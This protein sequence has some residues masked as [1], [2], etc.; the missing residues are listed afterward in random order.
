MVGET[1]CTSKIFLFE[2]TQFKLLSQLKVSDFIKTYAILFH[3][4]YTAVAGLETVLQYSINPIL[5]E[6]GITF[7]RCFSANL[8]KGH[9]NTN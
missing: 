3:K 4:S 6:M 9:P 2:I 7:V 1:S 8:Q 5:D